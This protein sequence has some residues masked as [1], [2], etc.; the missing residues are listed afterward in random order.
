[1][2]EEERVF[3]YWEKDTQVNRFM[4]LLKNG[5]LAKI[6]RLAA[7]VIALIGMIQV[8]MQF[9]AA[10]MSY[11]ALQSQPGQYGSSL[12][13]MYSNYLIPN[14]GS[15]LQSVITTLFYVV[16][17]YVAGN[18]IIAFFGPMQDEETANKDD[19]TAITYESLD[20]AMIMESLDKR[21]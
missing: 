8:A 12:A 6:C 10:W 4:R 2:S 18:I 17:L 15:A 5:R 11:Q 14:I 3:P 7:L 19:E 13:I 1:L 16:V 9:Y 20:N 21:R